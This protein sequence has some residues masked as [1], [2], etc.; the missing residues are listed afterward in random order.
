[1]VT[2]SCFSMSAAFK[3]LE[4]SWFRWWCIS[5]GT[6][7]IPSSQAWPG[8]GVCVCIVP[9]PSCW[10]CCIFGRNQTGK[11]QRERGNF[12]SWKLSNKTNFPKKKVNIGI[13]CL[14]IPTVLRRKRQ[15][16]HI[17]KETESLRL[18]ILMIMQEDIRVHYSSVL[19]HIMSV[20]QV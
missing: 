7:R 16:P 5:A 11:I 13:L 19:P 20:H 2:F 3:Q 14:N 8:K 18:W 17:M 15:D 6:D 10:P 9:T 4:F 1:M 12:Q